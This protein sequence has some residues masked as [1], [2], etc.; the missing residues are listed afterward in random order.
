ME[1]TELSLNQEFEIAKFD[2]LVDQITN[3]DQLR[4]LA[5]MVNKSMVVRQV[6]LQKMLFDAYF[7]DNPY[8]TN[9]AKPEGEVGS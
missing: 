9:Q 3:V 8:V 2:S 4:E 5:K 7:K 6:I 1:S